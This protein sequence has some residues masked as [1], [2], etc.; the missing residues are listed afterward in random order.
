MLLEISLFFF[1]ERPA[2]LVGFFFCKN[3]SVRGSRGIRRTGSLRGILNRLVNQR[4]VTRFGNGVFVFSC[5][6]KPGF[7]GF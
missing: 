6:C 3:I 2:L 4:T 1:S 5:S 7:L